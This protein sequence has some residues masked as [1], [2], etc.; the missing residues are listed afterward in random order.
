MGLRWICRGAPPSNSLNASLLAPDYP[1]SRY[2]MSA[3]T[4]KLRRPIL[5]GTPRYQCCKRL[6]P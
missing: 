1:G 5:R 6:F 4:V 3:K 2:G